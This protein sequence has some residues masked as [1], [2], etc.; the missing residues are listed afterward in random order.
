MSV[1]LLVILYFVTEGFMTKLTRSVHMKMR[2]ENT[3]FGEGERL[4]IEYLQQA[5]PSQWNIS[6]PFAL[7]LVMVDQ[8]V[9]QKKKWTLEGVCVLKKARL[10]SKKPGYK[11]R[12]FCSLLLPREHSVCVPVYFFILDLMLNLMVKNVYINTTINGLKNLYK[13]YYQC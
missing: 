9:M 11:V 3:L 4:K 13:T 6:F 7:S 2:H 8:S 5:S 10:L 1:I 12:S